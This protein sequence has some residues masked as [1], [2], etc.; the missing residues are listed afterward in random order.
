[1]KRLPV[2]PTAVERPSDFEF[3]LLVYIG[4]FMILHD[5]HV[6]VLEDAGQRSKHVLNLLG[7]ANQPRSRKNLFLAHERMM[8]NLGALG[9]PEWMTA[10]PLFDFDDDAAWVD[11]VQYLTRGVCRVM[12]LDPAR[13]GIIGHKKDD[14]SFYLDLFP[15][16]T[17]VEAPNYGNLSSTPIRE[18]YFESPYDCFGKYGNVIPANVKD[19]LISFAKTDA[20][21][22]LRAQP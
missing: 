3:D 4:R 7:S 5:G 14:S 11:M 16:W 8:M 12:K 10:L 20:Y 22:R 1:M 13:V 6:S 19:Y 2:T 15:D 17:L 18:A 21:A 9:D